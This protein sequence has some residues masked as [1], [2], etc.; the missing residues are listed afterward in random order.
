[1][2]N[3]ELF[4]EWEKNRSNKTPRCIHLTGHTADIAS[5]YLV[6]HWQRHRH[7]HSSRIHISHI[8]IECDNATVLKSWYAVFSLLI[9][10]PAVR[11]TPCQ[12]LEHFQQTIFVYE[13]SFIF[14][15][16]LKLVFFVV[17]NA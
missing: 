12:S 13:F 2:Y 11:R 4:R 1:M 17:N 10:A 7:S 14:C 16:S 8:L 5:R 6:F 3:S 9:A 15:F